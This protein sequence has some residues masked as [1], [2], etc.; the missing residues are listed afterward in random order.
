PAPPL[1]EGVREKGE[2]TPVSLEIVKQ[3]PKVSAGSVRVPPDRNIAYPCYSPDD[4]R[5][6]PAFVSPVK[7]ALYPS[8][9]LGLEKRTEC[10]A[11]ATNREPLAATAQGSRR[12]GQRWTEIP[13]TG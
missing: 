4:Y 13:T 3:N 11:E 6:R 9:G 7:S 10:T 8:D 5:R 1:C 2:R 12:T